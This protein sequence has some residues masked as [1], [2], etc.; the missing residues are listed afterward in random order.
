M[1]V[2]LTDVAV[3]ELQKAMKEMG[4]EGEGLKILVQPGGCA[5][6][7]Y[8]LVFQ[9]SPEEGDS[10][11]EHNGVKIYV[12]EEMAPLLD[13][14][15]IDYVQTLMG[16]GFKIDNPNATSSCGCGQSFG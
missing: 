2:V 15:T 10:I 14:I 16:G 4:K 5:G 1:Q 8:G 12:R 9:K 6:F 13:G 7:Q 3:T 11:I